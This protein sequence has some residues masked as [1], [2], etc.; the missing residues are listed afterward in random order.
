MI[1]PGMELEPDVLVVGGGPAGLSVA[2]ELARL[3]RSVTVVE[4]EAEIGRPVHTS[5]G[6]AIGTLDSFQL[7]RTCGHGIST[8][9]FVGPSERCDLVFERDVLAVLDVTGTYQFL[10]RHAEMLGASVACCTRFERTVREGTSLTGAIVRAG[11]QEAEVRARVLVDASG[12]RAALSKDAGLHP[13]FDRFGVGAEYE[14]LAPNVD[15]TRALLIVGSEFAPAGY[16]WVFPWGRDRVRI[17]VGVHHAD[18]RD[19]PR[20]LLDRMLAAA[21]RLGLD[22]AGAS[23]VEYHRGLIPSARTP[24]ALTGDGILAVG[25]SGSQ[26]TLVVGEGIRVSLDAGV[27]AAAAIHD[28]LARGDVSAAGL[29]PYERA[30]RQRYGRA[31]RVG[32]AMNRRLAN[33]RDSDWDDSVRLLSR[34]PRDFVLEIL[35]AEFSLLSALRAVAQRPA[36]APRLARYVYEAGTGRRFP[37]RPPAAA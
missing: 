35:Q 10:A 27:M 34:L 18:V 2:R 32:Y 8:I 33:Q 7:P 14:Y 19:D 11:A 26:A 30:F 20:E 15:Q 21:P 23:Q 22:M 13:G 5:G 3:G 25:D 1:G 28:A 37:G 31:G 29:A 4:R 6:T 24:A 17:G 9:T 12:Y 16:G 36:L